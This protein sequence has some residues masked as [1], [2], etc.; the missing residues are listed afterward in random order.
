MLRNTDGRLLA[1]NGWRRWES[2]IGRF[3]WF[4][5]FSN[6]F[7]DRYPHVA[8]ELADVWALHA[9]FAG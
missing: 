8:R 1:L 4:R 3:T 5:R 9:L 2:N 6:G 7:T